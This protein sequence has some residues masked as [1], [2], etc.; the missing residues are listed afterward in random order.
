MNIPNTLTV[1]RI[2]LTP[3]FVAFVAYDNI[4]AA[5]IVFALAGITDALDGFI[6]KMFSQT[7]K[8][9]ANMDPVAD[10]FLL[11]SAFI[12]LGLKGIVPLWLMVLVILR[13]I[14]ILSGVLV[15]RLSGRS[16]NI[17]PT[18]SGKITTVLQIAV[19]MAALLTA[20]AMSLVI[21]GISFIT[22]AFTLYSG[23]VY[24]LR[25]VGNQE[26]AR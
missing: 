24:I 20:G 19:I 11:V 5:A 8:F 15:L 7:T 13:D 10:K 4:M 16:V 2:L 25:E 18:F 23:I 9:G 26:R 14:T 6:A 3:L 22:A 12:A 1:V 17:S 21:E